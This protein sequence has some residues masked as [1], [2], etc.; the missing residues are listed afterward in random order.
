M[1]ERTS[2]TWAARGW[3]D[4]LI[5]GFASA[6]YIGFAPV[7]SGT[8]GS[9]PALL[10]ALWLG[11]RPVH[12]LLLAALLFILGVAAAGKTERILDKHDP[13]EVV[14]DEFVGMLIA[15]AWLPITWHSAALAFVLYRAFDVFKPFPA[16]QCESIEGGLGI[17]ADDIVAGVY[18][19]LAAHAL[20]LAFSW[21]S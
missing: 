1:K 7:A 12:L 9:L 3:T 10:V 21:I 13:S 16:R 15:F 14:I 8:F 4:I 17:M 11:H 5:V 2:T 6:L 18:A 19:N 20:I